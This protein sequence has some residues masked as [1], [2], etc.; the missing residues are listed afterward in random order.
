MCLRG[1]V[2]DVFWLVYAYMGEKIISF[3]PT[4]VS[5]VIYFL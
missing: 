5:I 4:P 2:F 1:L 3:F